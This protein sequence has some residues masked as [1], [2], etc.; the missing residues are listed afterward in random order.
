MYEHMVIALFFVVL[1][2][3]HIQVYYIYTYV[4]QYL[5]KSILGSL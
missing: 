4:I 1:Q 3:T 2:H 5:Y